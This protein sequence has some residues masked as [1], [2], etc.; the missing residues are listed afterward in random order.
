MLAVGAQAELAHVV[1]EGFQLRAAARDLEGLERAAAA[2]VRFEHVQALLVDGQGAVVAR[3]DRHFVQALAQAGVVDGRGRRGLGLRVRGIRR[4]GGGRGR[5]DGGGLVGFFLAR[6]LHRGARRGLGRGHFRLGQLVLGLEGEAHAGLQRQRVDAD[7]AVEHRPHV[8]VAP[9]TGIAHV[10]VARR[11]EV[12]PLPVRREHRRIGRV[13]VGGNEGRG[14]AGQ[15]VH[16]DLVALLA[17]ADAHERQVAAVGRPHD[18][19]RT[20][21]ADLLRIVDDDV[22][23]GLQVE[24]PGTALL[25]GVGQVPAVRRRVQPGTVA[26]AVDGQAL[27][28]ARAVGGVAPD[29]VLA[30]GVHESVD[31]LVVVAEHGAAGARAVRH[32]DLDAAVAAGAGDGHLAARG[33]HDALGLVGDVDIGQRV[34]RRAHAAGALL[35][36]VGDQAGLHDRV[37]AGGDV[38]HAQVGAQLVGDAAVAERGGA[39][40]PFGVPGVRLAVAAVGQ[41]G[42]DVVGAARIADEVEAALPPHG[43]AVVG[44]VVLE[45][46]R[47]LA[48]GAEFV[49]PQLGMGAAAVGLDVVVGH[50]QAHAREEHGAAVVAQH[51]IV[52]VGQRQHAARHLDGVEGGD[53]TVFRRSHRIFGT[54]QHLA[55]RGP[56]QHGHAAVFK[57]DAL[58]QAALDRHHVGFLRPFIRGGEGHELAVVR[59]RGLGFAG[60]VRGEAGRVAAL[61]CRA[62]QVT[63]GGEDD[64]V[65]ADGGETEVGIGGGLAAD[66]G[67]RQGKDGAGQGHVLQWQGL[68]KRKSLPQVE[69]VYDVHTCKKCSAVCMHAHL[70]SRLRGNDGSRVAGL[71]PFLLAC[72][73]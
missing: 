68:L 12:Q 15:V 9:G 28:L 50:R 19:V 41:R 30:G 56:A 33:Q 29:F 51:G 48:F 69:G 62:P 11:Q 70:G 67:Q 60:G 42:P 5:G 26:G 27:A 16:A 59:D 61:R 72:A 4:G 10:E 47:G 14:L 71:R 36:E 32:G 66:Q 45:Q 8:A 21:G 39:H 3:R 37:G 35:V 25:V 43:A 38:E 58:G 46:A 49:A 23:P 52:G 40:V 34:Q 55:L 31:P 1:H 24:Q 20:I 54:D 6:G 44:I 64:A 17:A 7:A 63:L 53:D 13:A 2:I 18:L 57:R 22:G 65:A 73:S